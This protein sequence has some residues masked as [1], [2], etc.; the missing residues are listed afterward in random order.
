MSDNRGMR[1]PTPGTV[2]GS[3]ALFAALAGGAYAGVAIP[4]NSV[5]TKQVRDHSLLARD[6]KPGQ[7]PRGARGPQGPQ[8]APGATGA[9]GP[10]GPA[11]P[12][13]QVTEVQGPKVTLGPDGAT[14][15]DIGASK[16]SCPGTMKVVSG[17]YFLNVGKGFVTSESATDSYGAWT[18]TANNDATTNGTIQA[19]A[20]CV[21][22]S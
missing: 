6:F 11:A 5:T 22:G 14:G 2:L 12:P 1:I 19:I 16:A 9:Q 13:L 17:G 21:P 3:V 4:R 7:V 10:Q 8:G 20:Y 15:N 18:V